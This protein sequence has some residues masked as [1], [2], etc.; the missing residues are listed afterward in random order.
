MAMIISV[1]CPI[2]LEGTRMGRCNELGSYWLAR[3][4][5]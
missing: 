5:V 1:V 2:H 4:R 3:M